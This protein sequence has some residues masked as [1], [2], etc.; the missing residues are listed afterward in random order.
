MFWAK[1]VPASLFFALMWLVPESPRWLAQNDQCDKAVS[2]LNRIGGKS[3]AE[4]AMAVATFSL[5]TT[6]TLLAFLFPI[7]NSWIKASGSF[8][9]FAVLCLGGFV[10]MQRKLVETKGKSLEQIEQLLAP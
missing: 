7:L 1:G 9:L 4:N 6:S 5:W 2:I 3:Y 8:W 10:F